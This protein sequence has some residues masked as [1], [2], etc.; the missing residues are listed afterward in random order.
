MRLAPSVVRALLSL[1]A[2]CSYLKSSGV[3]N[4]LYN[5]LAEITATTRRACLQYDFTGVEANYTTF[6]DFCKSITT[7]EFFDGTCVWIGV[8]LQA[9]GLAVLLFLIKATAFLEFLS[10]RLLG[11]LGQTHPQRYS[12]YAGTNPGSTSS[13]RGLFCY[14]TPISP[15]GFAPV[16]RCHSSVI[17]C[18]YC[19]MKR[20]SGGKKCSGRT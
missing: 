2:V 4:F 6:P 17:L 10:G 9:E 16:F 14:P 1:A 7:Q 8:E 18:T 5:P 12:L 19:F 11:W 13:G 20:S 3:Q 15:V